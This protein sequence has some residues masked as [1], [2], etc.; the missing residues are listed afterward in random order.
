[1]CSTDLDPNKCKRLTFEWSKM[2]ISQYLHHPVLKKLA[3]S[4]LWLNCLDFF[5]HFKLLQNNVFL[6]SA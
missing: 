2:S 4:H 5:L 1:M 3:V 6:Y